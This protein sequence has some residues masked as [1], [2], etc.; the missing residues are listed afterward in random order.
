MNIPAVLEEESIFKCSVYWNISSDEISLHCPA[1]FGLVMFMGKNTASL[2]VAFPLVKE[3]Q[4]CGL[5]V[6]TVSVQP[7]VKD[8]MDIQLPTKC[9]IMPMWVAEVEIKMIR[10]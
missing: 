1:N 4:F 8:C 7:I 5:C 3:S 2:H 9:N 10:I 6:S